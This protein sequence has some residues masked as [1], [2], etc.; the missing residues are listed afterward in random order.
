M[1][2]DI[3][4]MYFKRFFELLHTC[5][6]NQFFL[7]KKKKILLVRLVY[8][9]KIYLSEYLNFIEK[10]QPTFSLFSVLKS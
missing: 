5:F 3:K 7:L 6:G 1:N 8:Y 4:K 9:Y 10:F 2:D